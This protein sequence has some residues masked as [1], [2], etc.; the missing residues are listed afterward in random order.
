MA[1]TSQAISSAIFGS[2]LIP[3]SQVL[4]WIAY[5]IGEA[6]VAWASAPTNVLVSGVST[7]FVGAG[8][9]SGTLQ[10]VSADQMGIAFLS[11]PG[12]GAPLLAQ[13]IQA[14]LA[15]SLNSAQYQGTSAGVGS[16]S[17]VSKVSLANSASLYGVLLG[18]MSGQKL[19]GLSAPL[20]A[21]AIA[22]GVAAL[23]LTG[24]GFGSVTGIAGNVPAV[25]TSTSLVL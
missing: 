8:S 4:P 9:V 13:T 3:G 20:L 23:F 18:K 16:G 22:T 10:F 25:G 12:Q 2:S 6:V 19:E 5:S 14:G 1:L 21:N 17:D 24:F 15:S 11:L 7:G